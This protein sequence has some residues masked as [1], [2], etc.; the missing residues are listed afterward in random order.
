MDSPL[1]NQVAFMR[2]AASEPS[3]SDF[4]KPSL[5]VKFCQCGARSEIWVSKGARF[6]AGLERR[7]LLTTLGR[8]GDQTSKINDR[9]ERL[10]V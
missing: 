2:T 4:S 8:A 1:L 10:A 7:L 9:K 3:S 6:A 5:E